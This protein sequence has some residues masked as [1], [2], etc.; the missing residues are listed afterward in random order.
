MTR[1]EVLA[2]IKKEL[3]GKVVNW[4]EKNPR[5]IYVEVKPKDVPAAI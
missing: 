1:E 5:R 4:F 2:R 3:G